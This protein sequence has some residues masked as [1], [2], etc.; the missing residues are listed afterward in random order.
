MALKKSCEIHKYGIEERF[1]KEM[2][3][4]MMSIFYPLTL[5]YDKRKN[6]FSLLILN[7]LQIA[8]KKLIFSIRCLL[9]LRDGKNAKIVK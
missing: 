7:I 2:V 5:I 3:D 4:G 8:I 1:G 6:G 9:N